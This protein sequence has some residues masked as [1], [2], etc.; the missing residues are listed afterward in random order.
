VFNIKLKNLFLVL[1]L[2]ISLTLTYG[3]SSK[4]PEGTMKVIIVTLH[5]PSYGNPKNILRLNYEKFQITNE[6]HKKVNNEE[7][8]CIEVNY[9]YIFYFR[10]CLPF[11]EEKNQGRFSFIKRGKEWYGYN[12]W[13][14]VI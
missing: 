12:G 14:G 7:Y 10:N 6:F 11:T 3:C 4:P 9:K 1:F 8:Y 2:L 13:K 5:V